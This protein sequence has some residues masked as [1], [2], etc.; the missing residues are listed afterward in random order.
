MGWVSPHERRGLIDISK[1]LSKSFPKRQKSWVEMYVS[2]KKLQILLHQTNEG[3]G[4][5]EDFWEH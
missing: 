4:G 5:L 1:A 2:L 3:T